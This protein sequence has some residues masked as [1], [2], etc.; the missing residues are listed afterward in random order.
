LTQQHPKKISVI[1]CW[2]DGV[3]T[4]IRLTEIFRRHG[5]RATF[6]LNAGLHEGVRK[7]GW[8]HQST[9]VWRLSR[10]ELKDV[11]QGFTVANHTLTH[12]FLGQIPIALARKEIFEGRAQLQE[13]FG[14]PVDGFV[15]PFGSFNA[16]VAE[17]VR[18][19][20]HAYARTTQQT[21]SVFPLTDPMTLRTSCHFL[22]PDFWHRYKA[23]RATG[24]FYFWG[25]SYEMTTEAMWRDFE[26]TIAR[27][28]HDEDSVW[29][30]VADVV[31][32][33]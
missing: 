12:P 11:Y 1:Q 16:Q 29:C 20:G 33:A 17:L 15:Y 31:S 4:D 14:Q 9:E 13:L 8:L 2:D 23:S 5:A 27:I 26:S 24:L 22:A 28:T 32:K 19:A 25:H 7:L 18:E 10:H 6:N 3:T 30:D 21:E